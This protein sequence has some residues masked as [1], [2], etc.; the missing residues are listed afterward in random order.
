MKKIMMKQ[1]GL[2][3]VF[4]M[5]LVLCWTGLS[6]SAQYSQS[7]TFSAPVLKDMGN[8]N[9]YPEIEGCWPKTDPTGAP[10]L[11]RKTAKLFI[12]PGEKVESITVDCDSA[13]VLP[14]SHVVAPAPKPIPLSMS[15]LAKA[16][17]K[18][19]TIYGSNAP[20]PGVNYLYT[21]I[22]ILMGAP[23]AMLQLC[24][25]QYHPVTGKI[26]YYPTMTVTVSTRPAMTQMTTIF[27][28]RASDRATILSA[29]D[30]KEI[31]LKTADRMPE[32][33]GAGDRQYLIITTQALQDTMQKLA[34]HRASQSGGSYKTH[35][36]LVEDI[37]QTV[38]GEDLAE[39]MRNYIRDAY[40][41]HGTEYVVLGGD[42][43]GAP[44]NQ[45][46]PT[47][48]CACTIEGDPPE[49]NIPCD[50][51]FGCLDGPWDGNKNGIWGE[52]VDGTDGGDIDWHS[53]VYVGRINAETPE[54]ALA[55]INKIIAYETSSKPN[56]MLMVGEAL[57]D[58]PPTFGGDNLDWI[59]GFIPQMPKSTLYD[60]DQSNKDW[61]AKMLTD[62][63][64]SDEFVWINHDGHSNLQINMKL[65]EDNIPDINNS[66]YY[67]IYTTGCYAG[68]MDNR[69]EDPKI[70]Y[71]E[72]SII[73]NMVMAEG[74]GP[75]AAVAN[76]REGW[77]IPGSIGSGSA[78]LHSYFVKQIAQSVLSL[79]KANQ[80]PKQNLNSN[81]SIYRWIAFETNLF[82]DPASE[83][84]A[85]SNIAAPTLML[86]VEGIRVTLSWSAVSGA[87][88]YALYYAPSPYTGPES[89]R[90]IDMGNQTGGNV[91]LWSGA[92]FF[93]AIRAY[94][95]SGSSDYS[96]IEYF[97]IP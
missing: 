89:I 9:V 71:Q 97:A 87:S 96:N 40:Q 39:K 17:V 30:N 37:E 85:A 26:T 76:S 23:L 8:G 42:A 91:D 73:E 35:I 81:D 22:Q 34:D 19:P 54:R 58:D 11:P 47:R 92:S 95:S 46:L 60:R 72:D 65:T 12:P 57:D 29:V 5:L 53:E 61:P 20:Y 69:E 36:A 79:G 80:I 62:L 14:G 70:Y 67:F 78:L 1:R 4:V 13:L 10:M 18:D 15:H 75:F 2:A 68:S 45:S 6:Q 93:V 32:A 59:A 38:S 66:K 41:N 86:T 51:Y 28:N 90:S 50:L 77:Y 43:H 7:Y 16:A 82:G 56:K 55:Q 63:L 52:T 3:A 44:G 74:R 27:R 25:V 33:V 83:L 21:G 49:L 64:S 88:G 94:N 31:F 24:P 84:P 48:A